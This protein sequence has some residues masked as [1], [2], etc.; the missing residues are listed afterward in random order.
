MEIDGRDIKDL[1]KGFGL[2]RDIK[3]SV[4]I[5]MLVSI[6]VLNFIFVFFYFLEGMGGLKISGIRNSIF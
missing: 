5:Y 2:N 6:K 3:E 1:R 4:L